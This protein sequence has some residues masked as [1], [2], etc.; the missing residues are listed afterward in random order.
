MQKEEAKEI[1]E[2]RLENIFIGEF[3]R[4]RKKLDLTQQE[5]ATRADVIRETIA[6]IETVSVSPQIRTLIK[7]LKPFGYTIKIVPISRVIKK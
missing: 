6:R 4:L 2:E 3:L 7:I 1:D 5:M